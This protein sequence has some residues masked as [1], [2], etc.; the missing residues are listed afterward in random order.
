MATSISQLSTGPRTI[1]KALSSSTQAITTGSSVS[2]FLAALE[3]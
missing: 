3:V 2:S 1:P